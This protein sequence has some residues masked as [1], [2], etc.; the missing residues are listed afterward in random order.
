MNK[1]EKPEKGVRIVDG[2]RYLNMTKAAS[3]LGY[4]PMGWRK[5]RDSL[6]RRGKLVLWTFNADPKAV[7][8]LEEDLHQL[9]MAPTKITSLDQLKKIE[10]DNAS[11]ELNGCE[12]S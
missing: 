6:V 5:L 11:P 12:I 4:S 1:P 10:E 9:R 2:I 7:Y 8:I 3:D